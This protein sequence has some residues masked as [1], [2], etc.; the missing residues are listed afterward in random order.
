MDSNYDKETIEMVHELGK[1]QIL[2][3]RWV[4][5]NTDL[6]CQTFGDMNVLIQGKHLTATYKE[7]VEN[8]KFYMKNANPRPQQ[9]ID[10]LIEL[11]TK[12]NQSKLKDLRF[13]E[14]PQRRFT[15]EEHEFQRILTLRQLYMLNSM[16][17]IKVASERLGISES[18]IKQACQQ[19]RLLNTKKI[20]TTWEVHM[21]ECRAYWNIKDIDSPAYIDWKY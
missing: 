2:L 19:E 11:E 4:E 3:I 10:S 5:R 14:N 17:T 18:T 9:L 21:H 12:I 20:G 15:E 16:V 6:K 8:L 7:G 13:G 1:L